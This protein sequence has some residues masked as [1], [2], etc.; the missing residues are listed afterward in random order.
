VT[1]PPDVVG[2]PRLEAI[3]HFATTQTS[4]RNAKLENMISKKIRQ[5]LSLPFYDK[6]NLAELWLYRLKGALIYRWVFKSFGR[7]SAIYPPMLIGCP[8][9]IHIGD[10]AT[11]RKGVRLEAVL[12]DPENPPEIHIGNDVTIEQD[13]HIVAMGKLHIHDNVT[14]AA[15]SSL[16]CGTHPFFDVHGPVKISDRLDGEKS[17]LE[18][19]DGSLLGIGSVVHMNVRIGKHVVVGANSVVKRSVQD[20]CV[21]EGHPAAIVLSYNAEEDRWVR[22][23]KKS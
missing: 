20:Y 14:I 11:I 8:R 5:V 22:P 21:V 23:P 15:R 16:L 6:L 17:F 9:F 3:S 4:A 18:I 12:L 13:V 2:R 10:R 1:F 7:K 19:G